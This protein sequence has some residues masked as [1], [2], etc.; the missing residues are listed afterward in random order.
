VV[1][2]IGEA[3]YRL[4]LPPGFHICPSLRCPIFKGCCLI[5]RN[6]FYLESA[7]PNEGTYVESG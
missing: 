2:K 1:E 7:F 5:E 3:A 4:N 6:S